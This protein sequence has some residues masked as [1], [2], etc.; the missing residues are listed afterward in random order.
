MTDNN[1]EKIYVKSGYEL[2]DKLKETDHIPY[3]E[4][5]IE[6]KFIAGVHPKIIRREN[7]IIVFDGGT[8]PLPLNPKQA[9]ALIDMGYLDEMTYQIKKPINGNELER[10]LRENPYTREN[11]IND[12]DNCEFSAKFKDGEPCNQ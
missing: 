11:L 3:R 1:Y 12:L 4:V 2:E 7:L 5:H 6:E 10:I 8:S 9:K